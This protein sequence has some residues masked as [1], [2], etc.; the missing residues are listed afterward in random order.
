MKSPSLRKAETIVREAMECIV[1]QLDGNW[2]FHVAAHSDGVGY[3]ALVCLPCNPFPTTDAEERGRR[4]KIPPVII[5][6]LMKNGPSYYE[7]IVRAVE[8]AGFSDSAA[9]ESLSVLRRLSLVEQSARGAAY[10]LG[11]ALLACCG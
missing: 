8:Q 3:V 1:D 9:A 2:H 6:H 5:G 10:T 7:D 11:A 4:S